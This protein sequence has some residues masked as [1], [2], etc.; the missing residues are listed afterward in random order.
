LIHQY[1]GAR[2][3]QYKYYV[4]FYLKENADYE[5]LHQLIW[6]SQKDKM[7]LEAKLGFQFNAD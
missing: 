4:Y 1:I 5:R 7:E 6:L 2:Q 3:K